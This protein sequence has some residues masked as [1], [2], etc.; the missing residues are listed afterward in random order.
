MTVVKSTSQGQHGGSGQPS[1]SGQP[2]G[3][4]QPSGPAGGGGPQ[5]GNAWFHGRRL[6]VAIAVVVILAAGVAV[7][8][9]V[10]HDR[11]SSLTGIRPAG[12]PANV[13]TADANLMGLGPVPT[14][15]APGFTLTDQNGK[16]LSLSSFHGHPVILEFMDPHCTDICPIVSQEFVDAYHDLGPAGQRV[17][18]LAVN[19]NK[20]HL[21]VPGIAAF[22][23]AHRLDTIPTWHFFTGPL[24]ALESL[25]TRYEIAVT[26][27]GPNADV[28]HTSIIYFIGPGGR[29][30]YIASPQD[31]HTKAGKAFLPANEITA[32]GRGIAQV[33]R[34][35]GA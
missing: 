31:Y 16:T 10:R 11:Q 25:W 17:V 32:W 19:V 8:T 3:S 2:P 6:V 28:V 13:T 26:A 27:P 4:G 33:A 20:Y 22:S 5:G 7:G 35:L 18:F 29:E 24:P 21:G 12:I 30:R 15:R 9:V 14:H 34:D 1:G 23:K